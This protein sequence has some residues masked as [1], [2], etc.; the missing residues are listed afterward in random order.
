MQASKAVQDKNKL[1]DPADVAKD[2]YN[3]LMK[4]QDKV[5]SGMKNKMTV[6]MAG[7]TPDSKLADTMKKEQEP[8]T[9]KK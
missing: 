1:S 2:G 5:V 6:A 4:G 8:V 7:V 3:A 9:S